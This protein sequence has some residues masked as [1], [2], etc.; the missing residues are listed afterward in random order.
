M[1]DSL[2]SQ[3][4]SLRTGVI[5]AVAALVGVLVWVLVVGGDDDAATPAGADATN[6]VATTPAELASLASELGHPIY[7]A[8]AQDDAQL[9]LHRTPR[10]EVYVRYLTGDAEIGDPRPEYL[11]VGTYPFPD[12]H[13]S[14]SQQAKEDGALTDETPDGGL[15]LTRETKPTSVYIAFPD[16]DLQLEIFDPDPARAFDLATSGEIVPVG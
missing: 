9:E 2:K 5:I 10:G 4:P 15:V 7:W 1:A 14:L 6:A 13:E 11:T 12:A 8:G 3:L 16:R